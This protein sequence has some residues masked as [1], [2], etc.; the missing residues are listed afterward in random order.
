LNR[1][2]TLGQYVDNYLSWLRRAQTKSPLTIAKEAGSLAKW[3]ERFGFIRLAHLQRAHINEFIVWRKE[4]DQVS[5]RTV[6]LDVI[7][8]N[9]CLAHARDEGFLINLPTEKWK[10]LEHRSPRRPLW[11]SEQIDK[12]C[13]AALAKCANGRLLADYIRFLACTGMRRNEALQIK[14]ADV[15]WKNRRLTIRVTKYGALRDLD[16]NATTET[17][18]RELQLRTTPNGQWLFPSPRAGDEA[19]RSLQA[20]LEVA[21]RAAELPDFCFHDLRHYF[22]S[23]CVMAGIDY[24]TIAR[25]VGHRDGGVLIGRVYGHLHDEHAKKMAGLLVFGG[26]GL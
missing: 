14:W 25:G 23:T 7:A 18:L 13:Q 17:L 1:T 2:P 6:N 19:A 11:T 3:S 12:V 9:N 10:P 16:L 21:R 4:T 24:M 26:Q 5:N 22:I 15:D 8:L 20:S